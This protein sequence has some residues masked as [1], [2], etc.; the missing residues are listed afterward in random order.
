MKANMK[1]NINAKVWI[2]NYINAVYLTIYRHV[3]VYRP[4]QMHAVSG[5]EQCKHV[6][7]ILIRIHRNMKLGHTKGEQVNPTLSICLCFH[8]GS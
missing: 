7:C 8:P 3:C 5:S 2:P 1:A 6:V 4:M